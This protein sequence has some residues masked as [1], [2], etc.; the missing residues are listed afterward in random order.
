MVS[1]S[2]FLWS[3]YLGSRTGR[4][5][6]PGAHL[7]P[8]PGLDPGN[9][10]EVSGLAGGGEAGRAP[11]GEGGS[12][13]ED[14][15]AHEGEHLVG[16]G[17]VEDRAGH[18][19]PVVQRPL[20]PAGGQLPAGGPALRTP[21]PWRAETTGFAQLAAVDHGGLIA[22]GVGAARAGSRARRRPTSGAPPAERPW[23][24]PVV[25]ATRVGGAAAPSVQTRA[26]SLCICS[27]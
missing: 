19:E 6:E 21:P 20:G 8:M 7:W 24:A 10:P 27:S 22:E 15:G 3:R 13:L 17:L 18:L 4:P 16:G 14:V 11:L 1:G 25:P 23:P 26:S 2:L 12:T 5:G 9:G